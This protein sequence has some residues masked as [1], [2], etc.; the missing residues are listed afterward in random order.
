MGLVFAI[1]PPTDAR[2]NV[3]ST[4]LPYGRQCTAITRLKACQKSSFIEDALRLPHW[5]HP[6]SKERG[7]EV[8]WIEV[9]IE[10]KHSSDKRRAAR[11][12]PLRLILDQGALHQG[13][14]YFHSSGP[15]FTH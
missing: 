5:T 4:C 8:E 15:S 9:M 6:C 14:Y 1:T 3:K 7:E 13:R 10:D 2:R 12:R 11:P